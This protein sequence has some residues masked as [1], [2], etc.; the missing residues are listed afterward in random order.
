MSE[1]NRATW[2]DTV[3]PPALPRPGAMGWLRVALR[4]GGII[5]VLLIGVLLIVPLRTAERL[6]TGPRRPLT[7]PWVQG[8]C[9]ICLWILGL[10]W[11]CIGQPLRGPGAVVANHSSWLDIFVL[12]A[13]MPVFFVSKAE[14]AGWP[15]IN[16]LTRVTNTHFVTRDPKLAREQAEEFA[17][18]TRAGHRLLFFPEGTSSDGQRVLPFKPTLFQGF[19]DPS[20]PEDLAIQPMSATYHAPQGRDPRFYGWWGDMDLGPHLLAVLAQSPQGSVTVRLHDPIPVGGE[21]RKTLAAKAGTAV[22]EGFS[23][24]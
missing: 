23:Q 7:G 16:I 18:R 4:G 15:G 20:L 21:T 3:P 12:N 14:V 8:V 22:R 9:R 13:A 6:F 2:R 5:L 17:A 1:G 19:L 10:K 24:G 11:R